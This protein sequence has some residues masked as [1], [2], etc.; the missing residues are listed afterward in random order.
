[1]KN[2]TYWKQ[3][4]RELVATDFANESP[5]FSIPQTENGEINHSRMRSDA[6]VITR[7]NQVVQE[8]SFRT[9]YEEGTIIPRSLYVR[10]VAARDD[11]RSR[12][13]MSDAERSKHVEFWKKWN[14][15]RYDLAFVC[16]LLEGAAHTLDSEIATKIANDCDDAAVRAGQRSRR[17]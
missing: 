11:D 5:F 6:T 12:F 3:L 9:F 13:A 1:V 4:P 8:I 7:Q 10:V 16:W 15:G 17:V 14:R 2:E